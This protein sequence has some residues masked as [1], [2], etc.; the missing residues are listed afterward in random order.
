MVQSKPPKSHLLH[1]N[2]LRTGGIERKIPQD[3][4][5]FGTYR[6]QDMGVGK[7]LE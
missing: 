5:F 3:I 2:S 4:V 7:E 6:P 1:L